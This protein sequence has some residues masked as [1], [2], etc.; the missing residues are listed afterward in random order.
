MT[1]SSTAKK[2]SRGRR[3]VVVLV[4]PKY[5]HT[6]PIAIGQ[7]GWGTFT[8]VRGGLARLV[9][10]ARDASRARATLVLAAHHGSASGEIVLGGRT[11]LRVADVLRD[12]LPVFRG[13]LHFHVCQ[14]GLAFEA[15]CDE[16]NTDEGLKAALGAAPETWRLSG[17][18]QDIANGIT[19]SG[20]EL[21][22]HDKWL[23]RGLL[24]RN[25]PRGSVRIASLTWN[26]AAFAIRSALVLGG[27]PVYTTDMRRF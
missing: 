6:W 24:E 4:P 8:L 1:R 26:G 11:R 18:I 9:E 14:L 16:L 3:S 17:F 21:N 10:A 5:A 19:R 12:V 20:F 7:R 25:A 27:R 13:R 2:L 15:I 22:A 23:A